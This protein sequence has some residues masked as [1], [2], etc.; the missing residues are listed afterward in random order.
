MRF[1]RPGD[2]DFTYFEDKDGKKK[3]PQKTNFIDD[4][5]KHAISELKSSITIYFLIKSKQKFRANCSLPKQNTYLLIFIKFN[6][7]T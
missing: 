5:I 2:Y 1:K 3:P 7:I 4:Q 6:Y